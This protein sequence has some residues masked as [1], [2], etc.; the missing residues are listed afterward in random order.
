MTTKKERYP[1]FAAVMIDR[2]AT[3]FD[4]DSEDFSYDLEQLSND[5]E[6]TEFF[7]ALACVVPAILFNNITEQDKDYLQFNHLA[8]QL[9]FQF[10]KPKAKS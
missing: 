6:L 2:L 9:C 3:I 5:G 10:T 4:K 7:F 8:N 1:E